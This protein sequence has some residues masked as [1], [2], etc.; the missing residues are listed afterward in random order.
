MGPNQDF[1]VYASSSVLEYYRLYIW[2]G[3]GIDSWYPEEGWLRDDTQ[4]YDFTTP[5]TSG[6]EWRYFKF[7]GISGVCDPADPVYGADIDAV[8]WEDI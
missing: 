7:V 8:G 4:D 3:Q 1:T 6:K 5:S 2:T